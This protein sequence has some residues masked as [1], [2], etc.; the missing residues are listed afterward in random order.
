MFLIFLCPPST[1]SGPFCDFDVSDPFSCVQVIDKRDGDVLLKESEDLRSQT[2]VGSRRRESRSG[3]PPSPTGRCAVEGSR[4]VTDVRSPPHP[5]DVG[6]LP[7][8][9]TG[10]CPPSDSSGSSLLVSCV[11]CHGQ[12]SR[13]SGWVLSKPGEEVVT[14][15]YDTLLVNKISLS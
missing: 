14:F 8:P 7:S 2:H 3:R 15:L 13:K 6:Y 5:T 12:D 10:G 11:V 9:A 1:L 4:P